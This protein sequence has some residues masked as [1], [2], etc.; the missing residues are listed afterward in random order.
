M[1]TRPSAPC[2]ASISSARSPWR[3]CSS[4]AMASSGGAMPGNVA[5]CRAL[6]RL[7]QRLHALDHGAAPRRHLERG[8]IA[9]AVEHAVGQRLLGAEQMHHAVLDRILADEI[10]DRHAARL[11]LAPGACD[12]LLEL[13]R[14]PRQVDVHDRAR[15]LQIEADAAAVGRQEQPAGGVLLEA[16]DLGAPALLRHRAR[17]PRRLDA[18][19]ARQLAHHLQH[20]LPLGEHDHLAVRLLEQVAEH[21]LQLLELRADAAGGIEDRRRVADHAHAGEQHLQP[22]ELLRQQRPALRDA[23]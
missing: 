8:E 4:A 9:L 10:D 1:R 20:A 15:H 16:H 22:L 12:A 7:H 2:R 13:G 3:C 18:H 21:A 6:G 14:V 5:R 23:R 19:L 17:V 11:V